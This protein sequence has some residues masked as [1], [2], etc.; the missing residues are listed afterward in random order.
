MIGRRSLT[1]LTLLNVGIS[2]AKR[3]GKAADLYR[4][5]QARNRVGRLVEQD[6]SDFLIDQQIELADNPKNFWRVIKSVVPGKTS[7]TS[8]IMLTDMTDP[9]ITADIDE[10]LTANHINNF[11]SNIGPKLAANHTKR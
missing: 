3:T 7:K 11:F 10:A 4:A 9:N 5:K 2:I 6:K 8:K 1:L